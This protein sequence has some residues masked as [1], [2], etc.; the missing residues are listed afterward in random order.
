MEIDVD[1][2]GNVVED[3]TEEIGVTANVLDIE[4]A[5]EEEVGEGV[6]DAA[7]VADDDVSKDIV[8]DPMEEPVVTAEELKIEEAAEEE[9]GEAVDDVVEIPDNTGMELEIDDIGGW[10]GLSHL[11]R[12]PMSERS[13]QSRLMFNHYK[14]LLLS[15]D[16][17][18]E[19]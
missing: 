11:D 7:K 16:E 1:V 4:E 5:A 8:E 10:F 13:P 19:L 17:E 2:R 9:E 15:K 14:H 3:P 6:R 18:D 12:E